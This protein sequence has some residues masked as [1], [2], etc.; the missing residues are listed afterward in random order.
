M[1]W[2]KR[3]RRILRFL[4]RKPTLPRT[5]QNSLLLSSRGAK[6]RADLLF[7]VAQPPDRSA[8]LRASGVGF[9]LV[10]PTS[11]PHLVKSQNLSFFSQHDDFTQN[12]NSGKVP[13]S[14]PPDC[15]SE[16]RGTEIFCPPS[17]FESLADRKF[18]FPVVLRFERARLPAA[19]HVPPK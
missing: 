14:P 12:I 18:P 13:F 1:G 19:P 11:Y 6:R 17:P 5:H 7:S 16:N 8:L 15:Y 9:D 4:S 10:P 3:S 2:S